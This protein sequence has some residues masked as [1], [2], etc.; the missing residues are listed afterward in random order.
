MSSDGSKFRRFKRFGFCF[1]LSCFPAK[2]DLLYKERMV[3]ARVEVFVFPFRED[4]FSKG[5]DA[6][7]AKRKSQTLSPV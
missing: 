7:K 4:H 5:F 2:R 3:G 1:R 6:H